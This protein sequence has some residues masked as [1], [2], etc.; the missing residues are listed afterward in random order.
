MTRPAELFSAI[1]FGRSIEEAEII[2]GS[3][4]YECVAPLVANNLQSGRFWA[5]WTASVHDS[6]LEINLTV[7]PVD[8]SVDLQ[9]RRRL[10]RLQY[11]V[12]DPI[13][14][15]LASVCIASNGSPVSRSSRFMPVGFLISLT[16]TMTTTTCDFCLIGI[17][18]CRLLRVRP[19]RPGTEPLW[20]PE[21]GCFTVGRPY[22]C[23]ANSVKVN[24]YFFI[25]LSDATIIQDTR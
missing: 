17:S 15:S 18:F 5:R 2:S 13:C 21:A 23:P 6:P 1:F 14:I 24:G 4:H 8:I 10:S 22:G 20:I 7:F 3:H 12:L 9:R 11:S 25:S 16:T 19:D